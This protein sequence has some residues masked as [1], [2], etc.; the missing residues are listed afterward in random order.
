MLKLATFNIF[1][2]GN[3]RFTE[4]SE[5]EPRAEGDWLSI[6]RVISRVNADVIVFEEIVSLD[7]L[8][9]VLDLSH[10][11]VGRRYEIHDK[12]GHMLGTGK[13]NDQKVVIAYD[14]EKFDLTAASAISGFPLN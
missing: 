10:D 5:L 2:L 9:R 6:A 3:D 8:R 1:W 4:M 14:S 13:Q 11:L 12:Q 7:E